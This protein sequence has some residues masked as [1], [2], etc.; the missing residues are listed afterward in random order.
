MFKQKL[1]MFPFYKVSLQFV[2]KLIVYGGNVHIN[3][4]KGNKTPNDQHPLIQILKRN[5]FLLLNN[6][7][8]HFGILFNVANLKYSYFSKLCILLSVSQK[9]VKRGNEVIY[10]YG[11]K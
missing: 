9:C 10:M 1:S 8:R 3:T 11:I 4:Q 7:S 6:V 5:S 2:F